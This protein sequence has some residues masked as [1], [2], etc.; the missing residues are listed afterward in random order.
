MKN[1]G[2]ESQAP[3]RLRRDR[4]QLDYARLHQIAAPSTKHMY[5]LQTCSNEDITSSSSSL[6]VTSS[7]PPPPPFICFS[8][9]SWLSVPFFFGPFPFRPHLWSM[10]FISCHVFSLR[11]LS[12][13]ILLL[14]FR[15]LF[16]FLPFL[17]FLPITSPAN[18]LHE[19]EQVGSL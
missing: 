16:P 9:S 5:S 4:G 12:S 8:L 14:L 7:P 10:S 13:S 2:P 17:P 11:F 6:L 18:H 15:Y 3:A 19:A 1:G